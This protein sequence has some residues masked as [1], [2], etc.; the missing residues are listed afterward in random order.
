MDNSLP[1]TYL[2]LFVVLL[3]AAAWFVFRQVWKTRRTEQLFSR[4]QKKLKTEKG[5]PQEYYE[6]GCL[7]S[8]KKLYTKAIKLFEKSLKCDDIPERES[9]L[10]YNALGY[11]YVVKEQYDL[12]I[13]QYKEALKANPDYAI[14]FN[15][16]GF[17]YEK[18]NLIAQ[19]LESYERAL[20]IAPNNA[21][22]KKR[23]NSLQKR[24][25]PTSS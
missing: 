3:A 2:L 6:L 19:A 9:A 7:Y 12:A 22:A 1:V 13:R 8:D 5:T 21:T 20:Q 15:N 24:L 18:K 23:Y 17:A 25:S 16:I 4:L 14:A 11:V 10:V